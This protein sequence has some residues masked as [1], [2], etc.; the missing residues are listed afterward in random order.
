M[1]VIGWFEEVVFDISIAHLQNFLCE[2]ESAVL[3]LEV[4][5]RL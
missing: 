3:F 1:A 5:G 4:V 2:I